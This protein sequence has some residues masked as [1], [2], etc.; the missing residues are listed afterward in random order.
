[1]PKPRLPSE[2]ESFPAAGRRK[3]T[4]AQLLAFLGRVPREHPVAAVLL[5]AGLVLRVLA[6]MAYHPALLYTDTLKY[7]YGAWPGADPVG[8]TVILKPILFIGDLGTVA[9]IQHLL[10]LAIAV[11]IYALLVRRGV[12]RWLAALA[13][14]LRW[15]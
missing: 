1:V 5:A 8:Y 9:L 12:P 7:L 13:M 14:R 3:I 6:W 2:D 10:G 11:A 4:A 15:G